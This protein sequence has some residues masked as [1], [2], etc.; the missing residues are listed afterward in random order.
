MTAHLNLQPAPH[1]AFV[2]QIGFAEIARENPFLHP[3]L[4]SDRDD[5]RERRAELRESG[6]DEDEAGKQRDL[7][8]EDGIA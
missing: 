1:P 6:K 5:Q 8:D 7:S 4:N 3:D 2:G